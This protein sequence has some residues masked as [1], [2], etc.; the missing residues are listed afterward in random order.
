M[1]SVETV[2]VVALT[3]L[4]AG[5]VKGVVGL[6]LPTISLAALTATLGLHPAMALVLAPSLVTNVI[7]ATRGGHGRVVVRRLWPYLAVAGVGIWIGVKILVVTDPALLSKLLGVMIAL[8]SLL[9]LARFRPAIHPAVEPWIAPPLGLLNGV[10][11]GLTGAFV[12]PS[13]FYLQALGMARD[14]LVQ[15]MGTMFLFATVCMVLA[16]GSQA[17]ITVDLALQSSAAVIPALAG[18][19]I[20]RRLSRKLSEE[21]FKKLLFVALLV[22][23]LY[24]LAQ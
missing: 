20:G 12:V 17:F 19:M 1:G 22:L 7:Q 2:A 14:E 15:A 18:M 13:V 6:G 8:Y 5:F 21:M 11:T 23:G 3:F 4:I 9:S 10:L 24:I 16:L